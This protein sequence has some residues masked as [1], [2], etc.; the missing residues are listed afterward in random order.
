MRIHTQLDTGTDC[1]LSSAYNLQNRNFV[2]LSSKLYMN[3]KSAERLHPVTTPDTTCR[4]PL[5]CHP[6]FR[7]QN[8][9]FF[10]FY[11]DR[12]SPCRSIPLVLR[13]N[14]LKQFEIIPY[15]VMVLFNPFLCVCQYSWTCARKSEYDNMQNASRSKWEERKNDERGG[16][17]C[18][19]SKHEDLSSSPNTQVK[20]KI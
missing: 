8:T 7:S 1:S 5:P 13:K 12:D 4:A 20:I 3:C 19:T 17:K 15:F 18:L 14:T 6:S 9:I 16:S 2:K 10:R 11:E